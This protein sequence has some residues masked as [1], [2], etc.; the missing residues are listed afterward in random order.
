MPDGPGKHGTKNFGPKPPRRWD[1]HAG[2]P[3]ELLNRMKR[4]PISVLMFVLASVIPAAGQTSAAPAAQKPSA[5]PAAGPAKVAVIAFQAAVMKTNEF[6]RNFADLQKKYDP[7]RQQL[8]T[9]SDEIDTLTKQL[10]DQSAQMREDERMSKTRAVDDKKKQLDRDTQD[11]Q[12][13]FQTDMQQ[14]LS[15]VAQKVG[16]LMTDYAEKHGYTLVLDAGDQQTATVLYAV[17]STDITQVIID[18][19]NEKSGIP[20]PPAQ[21]DAGGQPAVDA[22][23]PQPA[24]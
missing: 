14:V 6:Q 16:A 24:H 17:P 1:R 12:S 13:D 2:T 19:Y 11:A 21:G 8:K 22:P 3:K 4:L 10:Q 15:G 5:A 9:L 23:Q 20:A 7:K 18:A